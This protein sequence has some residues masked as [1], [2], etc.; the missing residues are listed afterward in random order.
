MRTVELSPKAEHIE[1]Q[2]EA[3]KPNQLQRFAGQEAARVLESKGLSPSKYDLWAVRHNEQAGQEILKPRNVAIGSYTEDF[4]FGAAISALPQFRS[5]IRHL[6][7]SAVNIAKLSADS[8]EYSYQV[9]IFWAAVGKLKE[10][11]GI[12]PLVS[13]FIGLFLTVKFQFRKK[14]TP[15]SAIAAVGKGLQLVADA[16][17][18][19]KVALM[20]CAEAMESGGIDCFAFDSTGVKNA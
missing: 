6:S 11:L 15:T 9:T 2:F 17:R 16:K 5:A 1:S 4:M 3:E 18:Y 12:N 10:F 20:A 8:S 19:D 13:Q 7:E 14:D